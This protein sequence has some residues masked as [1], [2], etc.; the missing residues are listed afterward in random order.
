MNY[1]PFTTFKS[2][3]RKDEL[4][5]TPS[6]QSIESLLADGYSQSELARTFNVSRQAIHGKLHQSSSW[7]K[8]VKKCTKPMPTINR[9]KQCTRMYII[10]LNVLGVSPIQIADKTG[11]TPGAIRLIL[12]SN[13]LEK[14]K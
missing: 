8:R 9:W 11:Y 3:T 13:K 1:K 4:V 14:E 10:L 12:S 6:K 5:K 2:Q 7:V